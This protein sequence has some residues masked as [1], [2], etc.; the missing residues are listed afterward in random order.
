MVQINKKETNHFDV[1]CFMDNEYHLT[2]NCPYLQFS[3][4]QLADN[5]QESKEIKGMDHDR[6]KYKRGNFRGFKIRNRFLHTVLEI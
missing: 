5:K 4:D 3:R 1:S 2:E 6:V